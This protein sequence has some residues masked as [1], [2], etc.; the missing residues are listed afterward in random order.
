MEITAVI[1]IPKGSR[2]KYEVDHATGAIWLDRML[3]TA[4]QYPMDYGFV[5]GTLAPDGDP[6][7][8]LVLL[9]EPTFPGCHIKVRPVGVF[10]MHDE[11][12]QDA[13]VLAVPA[14]LALV[15]LGPAPPMWTGIRDWTGIGRPRAP[16][17]R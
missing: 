5:P 12:G 15:S 11:Q 14:T 16:S 3:F 13:K 17:R 7:D 6:L 8:V 2:N 9:E 1:E 10:R 4:T